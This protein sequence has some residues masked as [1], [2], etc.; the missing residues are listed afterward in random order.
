MKRAVCSA[1]VLTTL[2]AMSCGEA[3]PDEDFGVDPSFTEDAFYATDADVGGAYVAGD[4]ADQVAADDGSDFLTVSP[5]PSLINPE[6]VAARAAASVDRYF[7]PPGC[8]SATLLG[9]EVTYELEDCS[10]PFGLRDAS[11]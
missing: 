9:A 10:G 1:L 8:A 2:L 7:S 4:P 11:G 6:L 3:E 5:P